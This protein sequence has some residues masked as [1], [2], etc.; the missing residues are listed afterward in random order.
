MGRDGMGWNGDGMAGE[1]G[2][3]YINAMPFFIG[4]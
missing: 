4:Q 2:G 1:G 3:M